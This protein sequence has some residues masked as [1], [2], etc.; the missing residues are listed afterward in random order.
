MPRWVGF[1]DST[2]DRQRYLAP[3]G[4]NQ[5]DQKLTTEN[6]IA[7]IRRLDEQYGQDFAEYAKKSPFYISK[8]D[9]S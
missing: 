5:G 1:K 3:F 7:S 8:K 2:F 9:P 6:V 4:G